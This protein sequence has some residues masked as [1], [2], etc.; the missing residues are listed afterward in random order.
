MHAEFQT[1]TVLKLAPEEVRV[2]GL[3]LSGKLRA[4]KDIEL[5]SELNLRILDARVRQLNAES[6]IVQ[7]ARAT[8][9]EDAL[10]LAK[11]ADSREGSADESATDPSAH[12][13]TK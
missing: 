12:N 11:D 2:I 9:I 5:A 13:R 1:L 4:R 10:Q 8:A 3:G 7:G 6:V